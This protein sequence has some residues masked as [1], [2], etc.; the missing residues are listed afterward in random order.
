MG[1]SN[2]SEESLIVVLAELILRDRRHREA[3]AYQPPRVR[4]PGREPPLDHDEA[5]PPAAAPVGAADDAKLAGADQQERLSHQNAQQ[6]PRLEL[7]LMGNSSEP[8]YSL[9]DLAKRTTTRRPLTTTPR[10]IPYPYTSATTTSAPQSTTPFDL[11]DR[12]QLAQSSFNL[13]EK[14]EHAK[15]D[16]PGVL[17]DF[18]IDRYCEVLTF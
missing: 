8:S 2:I 14:L 18:L 7:E 6:R 4:R 3:Q 13:R 12:S 10:R 15:Q 1:N 11:A 16:L 5:A 17:F 9:S